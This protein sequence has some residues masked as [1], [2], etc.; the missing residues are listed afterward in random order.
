MASSDLDVCNQTLNELG[1]LPIASFTEGSP[2]ATTCAVAYPDFKKMCLSIHPW[3]FVKQERQLAKV[4]GDPPI[5]YDNS[6]QL[7][8]DRL[9]IP[10][11][12]YISQDGGLIKNFRIVGDRMVTNE[13]EV[14]T[15]YEREIDEGDW[16]ATFSRFVVLAF[17]H[18]IC[19]AV[20]EKV[21]L[22]RSLEK[23]AWGSI[24]DK[25]GGA[26]RAARRVNS[27]GLPTRSM[28]EDGGPLIRARFQGS[29]LAS[30]TP[31]TS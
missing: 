8:S 22:K 7:P 6:F 11:A 5:A 17:A 15:L 18:S 30:R 13:N 16:P 20:T 27:R 2:N 19:M 21:S 24:I 25:N 14:W 23:D 1:E 26:Y 29:R 12:Y 9:S 3:S 31:I 10:E 28:L 4:V